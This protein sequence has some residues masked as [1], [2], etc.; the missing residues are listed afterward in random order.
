MTIMLWLFALAALLEITL[1]TVPLLWPM[2]KVLAG[3]ALVLTGFSIGGIFALWPN[4]WSAL[5][6]FFGLYR[7]LNNL[8]VVEGRMHVVY[9][10]RS[11]RRTSL[12]LLGLQLMVV[13]LWLAWDRWHTSGYTVWAVLALAQLAMATIL[14]ASTMRR[15]RK[16]TWPR[17]TAHYDNAHLPSLTIAIPARNETDDL[18]VCLQTVIASDYPKL[19]IIVLDDCSQLRRTPEIIRNFAHNGVRFV[20][21]EAPHETWLPKN[22]AYQRL[23]DEANGS[24]ILFCG[25][26]ARFAPESLRQLVGAMLAKK[27]RMMSILPVREKMVYGRF[28]LVQAMRYWWE[29]VP[30]R[31]FMRRPAVL[32]SCWIVGK[33]SLVEAGGFAAVSRS[34]V[35]EAY[36]AKRLIQTDEYSFMRSSSTLGISS[37]KSPTD[38]RATAIRT[39]YPQLHRRPENV[40]VG[41]IAEAFFLL[42]PFV[43]AA[44]GMWV[45]IG[46]VAQLAV[47]LAAILLLASYEL[48]ALATHI[49]RWWFGIVALPIVALLD[50]ALLHYSMWQYEFLTIEWKGRNICI[51]AMHVVPHLPEVD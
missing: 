5:F 44:T 29:L 19:E 35:P 1:H 49:N 46:V 36:F 31:R 15:L 27:K 17:Q 16:T 40:A 39:R 7:L 41:V 10:R 23:T 37:D 6:L 9:L 26:D 11:T 2:R 8:R 50:I 12:A 18:Q 22:Q 32:S 30:P 51:P 42:C 3:M 43:L 28:A 45:H 25:V 24:F 48:M 33:E 47:V 14:L 38:Q 34:I 21:G 20:Q 13:A 4:A